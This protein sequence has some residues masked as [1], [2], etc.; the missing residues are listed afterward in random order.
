[1]TRRLVW[2]WHLAFISL[3]QKWIE[4]E[5]KSLNRKTK[6]GSIIL[7]SFIFF[8]F[9]F[10]LSAQRKYD[11][12]YLRAE[13]LRVQVFEGA[14]PVTRE[15]NFLKSTPF[16]F[17]TISSFFS[18][19]LFVPLLK[20]VG[21][22]WNASSTKAPKRALKTERAAVGCVSPLSVCSIVLPTVYITSSV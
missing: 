12:G 13:W 11:S 20:K 15:I 4:S 5:E 22:S 21:H 9:P 3:A 1:M 17:S 19:I 16:L 8:L 14:F 6:N 10:L 2:C 7:Q 18:S